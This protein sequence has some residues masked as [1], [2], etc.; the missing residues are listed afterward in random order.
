[1]F[2]SG[3]RIQQSIF[4]S[5]AKNAKLDVDVIFL[6]TTNT[7]FECKPDTGVESLEEAWV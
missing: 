1:M 7:Y 4:K 2:G 5:V 6:D 3:E